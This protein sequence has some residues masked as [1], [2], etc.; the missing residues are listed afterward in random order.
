MRKD[1][2]IFSHLK[3]SVHIISLASCIS[4]RQGE[5]VNKNDSIINH[6]DSVMHFSGRFCVN[7]VKNEL[8]QGSHFSIIHCLAKFRKQSAEFAVSGV[9][10]Q[11]E[12]EV[13]RSNLSGQQKW[14]L[15]LERIKVKTNQFSQSNHPSFN[16]NPWKENQK[17]FQL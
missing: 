17:I 9:N 13:C 1:L 3:L 12:H 11:L 7:K 16:V 4:Y 6:I 5:M 8:K 10:Q 14:W 15:V 2:P